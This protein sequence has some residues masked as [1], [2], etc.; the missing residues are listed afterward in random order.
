MSYTKLRSDQQ[1][2][3]AYTHEIKK[4]NAK[5]KKY[6]R[7]AIKI[8]TY[9][10]SC[11]DIVLA[12][13]MSYS[14]SLS[15]NKKKGRSIPSQVKEIMQRQC[16]SQIFDKLVNLS[17]TK[18]N[19]VAELSEA[20][21]SQSCDCTDNILHSPGIYYFNTRCWKCPCLSTL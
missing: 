2:Q 10:L 12:P 4:L 11:F 19:G 17:N 6:T 8:T 20:F 3:H 9:F 14:G 5:I 1:Q 15:K 16:H 21:S 18:G 13:R 7:S